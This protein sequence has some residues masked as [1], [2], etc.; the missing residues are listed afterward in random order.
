M[1]NQVPFDISVRKAADFVKRALTETERMRIPS[2]DGL[3]FE[4]VLYTLDRH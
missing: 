2:T 1:V 3:A 4:E